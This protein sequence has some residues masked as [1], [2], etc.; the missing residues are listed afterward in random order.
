MLFG[1]DL[2]LITPDRWMA[3]FAAIAIRDGAAAHFERKRR[4]PLFANLICERG[5]QECRR[6]VPHSTA[7]P[8]RHCFWSLI[9]ALRSE[10]SRRPHRARDLH[11]LF[12]GN[13]DPL[14]AITDVPGIAVGH[15]TFDFRGRQITARHRAR[16][17]LELPPSMPRG[18]NKPGACIRRI[19]LAER[20]RRDD[21][22]RLD[23]RIGLRGRPDC[24]HEH[25]QRG[26][27][28]RFHH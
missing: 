20:K 10:R 14:N 11:V 25:A 12:D 13:P 4:A 17:G 28:P 1:S 18:A 3:D 24:H 7:C 15:T 2:P 27:G 8:A 19:L 6:H 5:A 16:L 9:M 21:R 23:R 26:A 22:H